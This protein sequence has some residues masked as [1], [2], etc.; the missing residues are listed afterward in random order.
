M[1]GVTIASAFAS[2]SPRFA[3]GWTV[4]RAIEHGVA[5]PTSVGVPSI[6]QVSDALEHV[7]RLL[8]AVVTVRASDPATPAG[9]SNSKIAT[10]PRRLRALDQ[11]A[12]RQAD[13]SRD[14]LRVLVANMTPFLIV[15]SG[16]V[17]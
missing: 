6:V 10:E 3:N 17:A 13:P 12:D 16:K 5:G 11:E 14:L 15:G 1:P 8:V 7:D 4:P 9:T 2:T